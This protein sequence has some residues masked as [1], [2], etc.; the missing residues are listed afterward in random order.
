M[1]RQLGAGAG[2]GGVVLAGRIAI[3]WPQ[4]VEDLRHRVAAGLQ[5][6]E[7]GRF[8]RQM[9]EDL[10]DPRLQP[11]RHLAQA[12]RTGEPGA[13]LERVQRAHARRRHAPT[14]PGCGPSRATGPPAA[15]S[16]R[17]PLPRRS[18]TARR[19][20]RPR[21]R[22][23]RRYRRAGRGLP[24]LSGP[25][26]AWP[27]GASVRRRRAGRSVRAARRTTN[28]ARAAS[29]PGIAPMA[30]SDAG[31]KD[32]TRAASSASSAW[33]CRGVE[34]GGVL[35]IRGRAGAASSTS[36][37]SSSAGAVSMVSASRAGAPSA[38]ASCSASSVSSDDSSAGLALSGPP[39][40]ASSSAAVAAS[41]RRAD[42]DLVIGQTAQQV[43][44]RL[45]QEAGS[46]LMQQA[47]D[48][49]GGLD[50]ER[51]FLARALPDRLRAH[52]RMLEHAC[53]MGQIGEADRGRAAGQ[54][55]RERDRR[56]ADRAMQLHRPLGD[57]RGQAARELVGFV[58][59]D[60]EQRDADAQRADD[61]DRF[62]VASVGA[63]AFV[64]GRI[65]GSRVA[66]SASGDAD[67]ARSDRLAFGERVD[68]GQPV[69]A[70]GSALRRVLGWAS[71]GA[72]SAAPRR[73]TGRASIGGSA[74]ARRHVV[75]DRREDGV[76]ARL[77][78]ADEGA[79]RGLVAEVEI[80][81]ASIPAPR[82]RVDVDIDLAGGVGRCRAP[83][84]KGSKNAWTSDRDG[85]GRTSSPGFASATRRIESR[86]VEF[87][88]PRPA[89][90][91][92]DT[93]D[94]PSASDCDP[95]PSPQ[96]ASARRRRSGAGAAGRGRRTRQ[97]RRKADRQGDVARL[98]R[99]AAGAPSPR[100]LAVTVT[101][102][103]PEGGARR[104]PRSRR[105]GSRGSR[106]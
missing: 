64:R 14:R 41:R 103:W 43:G 34:R 20:R 56:L 69:E 39:S 94:E 96:R 8:G 36:T 49:F 48:L 99:L 65:G 16:A 40:G 37:A 10:L 101:A 18:G 75:V 58:E 68:S 51:R 24:R 23:R 74:G 83:A 77:E 57:F 92:A 53:Q 7:L 91:S 72:P 31:S 4:A 81:G 38:G 95:P 84:S 26:P 44:R 66:P 76:G 11:V 85:A 62:V 3:R 86:E 46:E 78:A 12:H 54:R 59:V 104:S 9:A 93:G 80:D 60:V 79:A 67:R 30:R 6:F 2:G 105:R 55:M 5:G 89:V 47:A 13:A 17:G 98:R 73:R 1:P 28:A 71:D 52:L 61:L 42:C 97:V 70:T 22:C 106:T 29:P 100:P 50:E 19:R 15:E 90:A 27:R 25:R 88:A 33:G 87:E 35:K 82:H 63:L 102:S 45:L 21:H 32:S